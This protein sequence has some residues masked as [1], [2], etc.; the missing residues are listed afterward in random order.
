M[1]SK[2]RTWA[3][4]TEGAAPDGSL[5]AYGLL[6]VDGTGSAV[7]IHLPPGVLDDLHDPSLIITPGYVGPERRDRA[8]RYR[9]YRS[10]RA[11]RRPRRGLRLIEAVAVVLAVV[12]ATVPLT[13]VASHS[14]VE[15][16]AA[17]PAPSHHT[18]EATG[19]PRAS[20]AAVRQHQSAG[21]GRGHV[22]LAANRRRVAT[23]PAIAVQAPST[24]CG[25]PG[26]VVLTA[27][28]SARLARTDRQEKRTS[29][30]AA[31]ASLRVARATQRAS[32]H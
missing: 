28:C 21:L 32:R 15:A 6:D 17:R 26:N 11:L 9:I 7:D 8:Q 1:I 14:M 27:R 24:S 31:R 19:T 13:L 3:P 5:S 4:A 10:K 25:L 29:L 16:S 23:G 20:R 18:A 2:W 12:A 30:R 22:R